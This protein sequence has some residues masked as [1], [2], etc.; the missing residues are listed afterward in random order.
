M[1]PFTSEDLDLFYGLKAKDAAAIGKL[2]D[3]YGG[4]MYSL[5]FR[6]LGNS[7]EAEDLIQEIFV[8]LWQKCS[9]DPTRGSLK[10][11]LLI[12]VRSRAID[13]WRS[14]KNTQ[15]RL[16]NWQNEMLL[17][18]E[19]DP[20][21]DD[22]TERVRSALTELPETQRQA[23]E[24]AYYQGLSQSE[25]AKQLDVPLGTVKSWFRLGFVKMRQMLKDLT[26][27]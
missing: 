3:R 12:L 8:N 14:Q 27:N 17:V 11:F 20:H 6:I 15:H 16:E 18:D 7:Q 1:T 22:I 13:R 26:P 4:L 25:I 2:Y 23:L 24:M 10:S 19:D 21:T 5:A 9:Y